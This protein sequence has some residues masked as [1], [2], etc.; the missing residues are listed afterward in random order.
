MNKRIGLIGD[1]SIEFVQNLLKIWKENDCAVIIDYRIP[2]KTA[3][4]MLRKSKVSECIIDYRL[5]K[6]N[7]IEK[8]KFKPYIVKNNNQYLIPKSVYD[9]FHFNNSNDEA[10]I[11]FSSGTTSVSKGIVLTYASINKNSELVASYMDLDNSVFC[12]VKSLAHSSTLI[13]ELLVCLK[14]KTKLLLLKSNMNFGK[15][16][17]IMYENKVNIICVNPSLVL[18]LKKY[19]KLMPEK[20]KYLRTIYIS[21]SFISNE[22]I[23]SLRTELSPIKVYNV[24]GLTE[25]GPRVAAQTSKYCTNNSVGV[26]LPGVDVKIMDEEKLCKTNEIGTVFV[27]TPC[28]FKQYI[29]DKNNFS[30]EWIN[31]KDLGFIGENGELFIVGR[32]DD[33]LISGGHN[34]NPIF[35]ESII[36]NIKLIEECIVIGVD[37]EYLGEKLV[38]LYTAT[39]HI[40][41][42]NLISLCREKL[43]PYEIPNEWYRITRIPRNNNGK[44]IRNKAKELFENEILNK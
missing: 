7:D 15:N 42:L 28:C 37:D 33:I 3:I 32:T 31:T 30:G 11:L 8:V 36:N 2:I 18:I 1:N 43:A 26:P 13:C 5:L 17:Q 40:N 39:K 24:Y 12:I 10:V 4:K 6:N 38:C 25:T 29:T 19:Y 44:I 34:V 16:I 20:Y 21:G 23:C 9:E 22:T 35:V 27:K 41:S 14:S